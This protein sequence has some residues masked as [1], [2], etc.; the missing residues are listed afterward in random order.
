MDFL[1]GRIFSEYQSVA[2][3]R[4]PRVSFGLTGIP[5]AKVTGNPVNSV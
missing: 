4:N 5:M 3:H 1:I 2:K